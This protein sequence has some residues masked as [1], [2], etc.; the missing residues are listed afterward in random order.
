MKRIRLSSVTCAICV[1]AL[2]TIGCY[3]P[4]RDQQDGPLLAKWPAILI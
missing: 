4:M 3:R 1:T 2:S